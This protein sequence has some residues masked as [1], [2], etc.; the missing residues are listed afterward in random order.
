VAAQFRELLP[1]LAP[2]RLFTRRVTVMVGGKFT[3]GWT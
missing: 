1:Q 2:V 3:S